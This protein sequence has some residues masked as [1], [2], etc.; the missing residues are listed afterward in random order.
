MYSM[1]F[2]DILIIIINKINRM[3]IYYK[4]YNTE[5]ITHWYMQNEVFIV[6]IIF[7]YYLLNR[8]V[9]DVNQSY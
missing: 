4:T 8:N 9:D 7:I 2:Q 5:N 1:T 6:I 3:H